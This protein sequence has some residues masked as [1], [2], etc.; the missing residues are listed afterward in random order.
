MRRKYDA[1]IF[2]LFG[3]LVDNPEAPGGRLTAYNRALRDTASILGAPADEFARLWRSTTRMRMTGVFPSAE[4]YLAHLCRELGVHPEDSRL[5][6]AARI[7]LDVVGRQLVPRQDSLDTLAQLRRSGYKIGLISDCSRETALHWPSTP[8]APLVDAAV[9][10][11]EVGV[12]K[13]DPGIYELACARL[14]MAPERCL[15]IGDGENDELA[16][17]QRVGMAAVRIRVPYERRPDD[18]HTWGGHE[19]SALPQ[20]FEHL[21]LRQPDC[22]S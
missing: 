16:G 17:A 8:L 22:F 2:D 14:G 15:Y 21:A 12:K 3:T 4:G 1:V 7:R 9:L 11:C 20:V 10:S 6:H 18:G 5:A 19:I 13:P